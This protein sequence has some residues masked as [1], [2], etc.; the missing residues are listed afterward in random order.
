[1]TLRSRSVHIIDRYVALNFLAYFLVCAF[2]LVGLLLIVQTFQ[3]LHK[4]LNYGF[5]GMLKI[6]GLYYL[7][8]IP[9]ILANIF[10]MMT[11]IGASYCLVA[12]SKDNEMVALK[13]SGVSLYRIVLPIFVTATIIAMLAAANQEWLLPTIGQRFE[14][15]CREHGLS[16]KDTYDK[17]GE[18][19]EEH[20]KYRVYKFNVE[21]ATFEGG[22]FR[23]FDEAMVQKELIHVNGEGRWLGEGKWLCHQVRKQIWHR[24]SGE[25]ES[26]YWEEY[27]LETGLTPD[28]LLQDDLDPNFRN[29]AGLRERIRSEPQ[30]IGLRLAFHSRF[31]HPLSA[32]ILLLIGLPPVVGS[33]RLSKNRVLGIGVS[34]IVG[35]AFFLVGFVCDYLGKHQYIPSA[36]L[37][38]WLPAIMFAA[39]GIYFFDAMRT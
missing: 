14:D 10:P 33:E 25:R 18:V 23:R 28:D 37:A 8:N 32:I 17:Y 13:A 21:T 5:V 22:V 26:E 30:R 24:E 29:L 7:Y 9:I 3:S 12:M 34:L 2:A 1:M 38:A 11:L 31:T 4:F 27:V 36:G 19:A 39:L 35:G 6:V 16:R 20:M 15:F